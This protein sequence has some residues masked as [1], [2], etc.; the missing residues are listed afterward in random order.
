MN[1]T[2]PYEKAAAAAAALS[3]LAF[4]A[5][6]ITHVVHCVRRRDFTALD[7][8]VWF[9]A[10]LV[11]IVGLILYRGLGREMYKRKARIVMP[12]Q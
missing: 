3:A 1:E 12:E 7:K 10:L 6:W 5:V 2:S 9:I 8:I 11:P 4:L